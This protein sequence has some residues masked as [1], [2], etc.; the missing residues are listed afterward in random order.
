MYEHLDQVKKR[1]QGALAGAERG[2]DEVLAA[3]VATFGGDKMTWIYQSD[4]EE[5]WA[6]YLKTE[7]EN[8]A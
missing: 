1:M 8:G 6:E 4:I 7:N 3:R 2:F 5:V